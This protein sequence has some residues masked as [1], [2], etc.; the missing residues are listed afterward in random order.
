MVSTIRVGLLACLAL[1]IGAPAPA[2]AEAP[3]AEGSQVP[4]SRAEIGLT[5]APVVRQAAPAVVNVYASRRVQQRRPAIFDDPFFRRFFDGPGFN[6]PRERVQNSLGSGVIVRGDGLIVTNHHVIQGADEVRVVLSD[7]REFDAEIMLTDEGTDLAVLRIAEPPADLPVIGLAP[8]DTLEV[9]DLVLAIGNPFGVGQTVTGGIVSAVARTQGGI[10]D[11]DFFIQTDAAINPGNSGGAL[12]DMAGRLVG[13]N[14]AIFSRSGGSI[15]IGFAIPSEM[16]ELVVASADGGRV[17]RPWFGARVQ[18]VTAEIAETLGLERPLGVLVADVSTG[19]PADAAGLRVGDVITAVDG[20][21]VTDEA[22]FRYRFASRG[23]DGEALL[24]LLRSGR[25][26]SVQVALIPAPEEPARDLRVIET[27][28]PLAGAEIANLSPAV[29]EELRLDTEQSGVVITRIA[30]RSPAARSGFRP[31][32][33]IVSLNGE[34]IETSRQLQSAV[35]P[36]TRLW[37][38]RVQRGN[39]VSDMVFGG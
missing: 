23:L 25:E 7:R 3:Q 18:G 11:L 16:V 6:A 14:T 27:P 36:G 35:T 22:S 9:G 31:G 30:R 38:L 20:R 13:I 12:V 29:A 19:G 15:G 34:R 2:Y 8:S 4:G 10:T 17:L 26:Q 21:E 32:D 1:L 5:F 24:S 37:R 33:I 28:S 39:R